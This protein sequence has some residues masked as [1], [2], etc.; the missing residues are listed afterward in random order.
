MQLV[1]FPAADNF[2]DKASR[3]GGRTASSAARGNGSAHG[4]FDSRESMK[5][6]NVALRRLAGRAMPLD[7]RRQGGV[8][9]ERFKSRHIERRLRQWQQV[10]S[11]DSDANILDRRLAFDGAEL[12]TCRRWLGGVRLHD[13]QPL[14]AWAERLNALLEGCRPREEFVAA[15]SGRVAATESAGL[16]NP[17][18]PPSCADACA[19]P[20]EGHPDAPLPFGD[21]WIQF[22][23]GATEELRRTAGT[24]LRN[25]SEHA[26]RTFQQGLLRALAHL[27]SLPMGLEFQLF[28]ARC[29][30]LSIFE[31]SIRDA[32]PLSSDLYRRFVVHMLGG[33]LLAFFQQ[34]SV[35][36]RLIAVS[37]EH[38]VEHVAEFCC[39]VDEDQPVLTQLF[40]EGQDLGPVSE[41]RLGLSD[42]HNRGRTVIAATFGSGLT[43]VYKPKDLGIDQAYNGFV[44]WLNRRSQSL[45]RLRALKVL[46]CKTHGWI[47]FVEHEPCRNAG[48]VE[49]YYH[50]VGMLLCL[51]HILGGR[52]FHFQNVIA[53]GEQPV[54]VDL[55]MMLQPMPAPWDRRQR[56]SADQRVAEILHDSVLRTSLLPFWTTRNRRNSLDLSGIG[57]EEPQD[58]GNRYPFWENVNTD[59]MRLVYGDAPVLPGAN[60][61]MLDG[62]VVSARDHVREIVDGFAAVYR[63]LLAHSD[64]LADVPNATRPESSKRAPADLSDW[65]ER[66]LSDR[67]LTR[68]RGLKLRCVLRSTQTYALF[69]HRLLHPEFLRDGADRSIELE[70]LARSFVAIDA[71]SQDP[72]S[73]RSYKAEIEALERL[74][75]PYFS[76]FSDEVALLTDGTVLAPGFFLSSGL[77]SVA[78]RVRRL[79]EDDL[80]VQT[81]FIRACLHARFSVRPSD[82]ASMAQAVEELPDQVAPGPGLPNPPCDAKFRLSLDRAVVDAASA[83]S[84]GPQLLDAAVAIAAQIRAMAIRGADGGATWIALTFD[85]T[86]ER[87]NLLP[88][89]DDLYGGRIGVA[90]FLAALE[91]A[92]GGAGFRELALSA[93]LPLRTRLQESILSATGQSRLGGADGM[94]SQL[95]ALVR[96]ADWLGDGELLEL[97][98]RIAHRFIPKRIAD[99]NALDI[100]GGAAGGILGLLS[101][102]ASSRNGYA[103]Q[104]AVQCGDHLL[105]RRDATDTG[106]R[107]W[108]VSW[109]P[110]PLTG[111]SHGAAGI[112]YALLRLSQATS[113]LRFRDAAE[114]G[115]AYETA[116]YSAKARNWP[117]YRHDAASGTDQLMVA[118][119]HGAPGIGLARLGGLPVLD[120]PAIRQDIANA[121]ETTLAAS[122]RDVDHI[123]CGSMGCLEFLLEASRRLGRPELLD[124]ARRRASRIVRRAVETGHY[125]LHA[126]VPD[127]TDSPSLFQGIAGIG[128][129]LLRLAEPAGLPSVLLWEQR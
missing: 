29:N 109:A 42:P 104:A 30:P 83:E 34:Y 52:D 50:R 58:S 103:L 13:D 74:D 67:P 48:E 26:L 54:L 128:Y 105:K 76:F 88:M 110:R 95:Y 60:R 115:I 9:S 15:S 108:R 1:V 18:L 82:V 40:N 11:I 28:V 124:E 93:T 23:T 2:N 44:E 53:N 90:L 100:I 33:G 12:D 38:W 101:L 85:P 3:K 49:R 70:R 57:A 118:W 89:G 97:A 47:E 73:W 99:D 31:E 63:F 25:L 27:A 56:F 24:S 7:Q 16:T 78:S 55:E 79:S 6:S 107:S 22:V 32:S 36:A 17:E 51:A 64:E 61:P 77:E 119:C 122:D 91:H 72:P 59:R 14:P 71:D 92:T 102:S 37:V 20:V 129:E 10:L 46:S 125:R 116:V 66:P 123:C 87:M 81:N 62:E 41:V 65:N 35:L 112:A 80:T 120:T 19:A 86:S 98:D 45:L 127:V 126:Q 114:E 96:I 121:L 111:F 43:I 94:G 75:I 113:E 21:V 84:T 69:S 106:H 5:Y 68:L 8:I 117:D 4:A 39:R